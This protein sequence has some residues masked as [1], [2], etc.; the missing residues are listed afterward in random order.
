MSMAPLASSV[1]SGLRAPV[2]KLIREGGLTA[3]VLEGVQP[4]KSRWGLS[5]GTQE[6]SRQ[7]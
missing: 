4:L 1:D 7:G 6:V 3:L 5:S 2:S